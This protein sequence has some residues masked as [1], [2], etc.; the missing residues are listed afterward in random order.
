MVSVE[1]FYSELAANRSNEVFAYNWNH[2]IFE[3]LARVCPDREKTKTSAEKLGFCSGLVKSIQLAHCYW[4]SE[5]FSIEF[6]F[7]DW[8]LNKSYMEKPFKS[9]TPADPTSRECSFLRTFGFSCTAHTFNAVRGLPYID[10]LD[11][12]RACDF[13]DPSSANNTFPNSIKNFGGGCSK[14]NLQRAQHTKKMKSI[15]CDSVLS[16]LFEGFRL[17]ENFPQIY[18]GEELLPVLG[19]AFT[20]GWS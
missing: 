5:V 18:R 14:E 7:L 6:S 2:V 20:V 16:V 4:T 12:P 10:S 1:K 8:F 9:Q 11:T 15:C 13:L 17:I 3:F 19:T